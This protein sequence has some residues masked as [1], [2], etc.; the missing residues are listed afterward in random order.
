MKFTLEQ[1]KFFPFLAWGLVI[2]FIV[3]TYALTVQ[4]LE[5]TTSL[6]SQKSQTETALEKGV[7]EGL[8]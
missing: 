7:E 3:F 4:L 8:K 5:S 1:Y 6:Q 2:G